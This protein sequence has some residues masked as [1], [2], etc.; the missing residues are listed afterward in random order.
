MARL[1]AYRRLD[2]DAD[3]R[4]A[5]QD[6]HRRQRGVVDGRQLQGV[7]GQYGSHLPSLV[8][9]VGAGSDL[10]MSDRVALTAGFTTSIT[11]FG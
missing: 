11:G 4:D 9:A 5:E 1:T 7:L 2:D 8:N 10:P 6:E 3:G